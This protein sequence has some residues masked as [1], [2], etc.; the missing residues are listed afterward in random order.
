MS[1][2]NL[3][4]SIKR[5]GEREKG[6]WERIGCSK[7]RRRPTRRLSGVSGL[8]ERAALVT[9]W[10]HYQNS[11][12]AISSATRPR[13][14]S[15]AGIEVR[16][17]ILGLNQSTYRFIQSTLIYS[18]I[19]MSP[20]DLHTR[21]KDLSPPNPTVLLALWSLLTLFSS[22]LFA[23]ALI[24]TLQSIAERQSWPSAGGGAGGGHGGAWLWSWTTAELERDQPY[25]PNI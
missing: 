6:E 4:R 25:L 18:F 9:P 2:T 7:A 12:T 10:T 3:E 20:M 24:K 17:W 8:L 21:D 15:R 5:N 14:F 23:Q 11:S 22:L 13:N 16:C 1:N 19:S